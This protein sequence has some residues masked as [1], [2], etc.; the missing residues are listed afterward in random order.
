M[1][2]KRIYSISSPILYSTNGNRHVKDWDQPKHFMFSS[3]KSKI[4]HIATSIFIQGQQCIQGNFVPVLNGTRSSK[5]FVCS[6]MS[7]LVFYCKNTSFALEHMGK[8]NAGVS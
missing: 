1:K 6:S 4:M 8:T 5:I 2:N 3:T 7:V